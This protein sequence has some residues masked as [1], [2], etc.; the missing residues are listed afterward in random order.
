ME[1]HTDSDESW[2]QIYDENVKKMDTT[3]LTPKKEVF[4]NRIKSNGQSES[5]GRSVN[6]D[7]K[8]TYLNFMKHFGIE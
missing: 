2:I 4:F 5:N 6:L 7:F 3:E 1:S 8:K